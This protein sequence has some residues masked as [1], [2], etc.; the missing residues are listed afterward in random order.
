MTTIPFTVP[1]TDRRCHLNLRITADL[2]ALQFS[3]GYFNESHC[4]SLASELKIPDEV[5]ARAIEAHK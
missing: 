5:L 4:K 3:Q 1:R 2:V